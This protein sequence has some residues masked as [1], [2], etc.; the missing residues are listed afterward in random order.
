MMSRILA[1]TSPAI[2]HLFPMAPLLLELK[3]RGH[4]VHVRTLADQVDLM[5]GLG[6]AA[7][8]I[9]ARIE[10]IGHH[11]F[12]ARTTL[13]A[14]SASVDVFVRR[15]AVDGGDL[16]TAA[17]SIGPDLTIVDFN[18]W[19]ARAAAQARGWPWAAF[20]PYT[21]PV[22]S[23]GTPPFG[24]GLPPLAGPVG[25]LRDRLLRPLIMGQLEKR[26]LPG[27]NAV[28][29]ANGVPTVTSADQFFRSAPLTLVA[30]SEP[31]EYPHPDW[32]PDLR[33]I[34]ALPW[35]PPAE[36]PEW[37]EEPGAPFVL[38]TTSSEYQAD[39]ALARAAVEGLA[40]EPYRVVVTMP[41]GVPDLRPLPANVRVERFIPHGPV[42]ARSAVA[43][44]HG[45][46]GATQKALAAGVPCVV[47]PFG[48]DQLEVAA[49]V[50]HAGAGIRVPKGRLTPSRLREAVHRAAGMA[51]GARR[52]AAGYRAAGGAAAGA[53]AVEAL[54][55]RHP[56][57]RTALKRPDLT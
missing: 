3:R 5:R 44:T 17:A 26:F 8:P 54:I 9:D 28:L 48:R 49:R 35:E 55:A 2:G 33:L 37:V 57:P 23:S 25:F 41:A 38:V 43:V 19:G 12:G 53:Q 24:P 11:D 20:C 1:Y 15:A 22:T 14:L 32:A 29:A 51:E 18:S 47:V 46:M 16:A 36:A 10:A 27:I 40:G 52:T 30:T 13:E 21:P 56:Q 7:E 45:G 4:E 42:L 39:E 50:K 31:F 34:G 6:L